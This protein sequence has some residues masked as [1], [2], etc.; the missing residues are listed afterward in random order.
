MRYVTLFDW[1]TGQ[2]R[3]RQSDTELRFLKDELEFSTG[4]KLGASW[5]GVLDS[6][7]AYQHVEECGIRH[8]VVY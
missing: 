1:I 7:D 4:A 5:I 8:V 3:L 6:G 2:E